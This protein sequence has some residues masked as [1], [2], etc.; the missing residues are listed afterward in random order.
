MTD[1]DNDGLKDIFVANGIYQDLTNEDDIQ[2]IS[3]EE[4]YKEVVSGKADYKKMIDLIPSN[5]IPN[6]AFS[7]NGDLTFTNRAKEWGLDEPSFSNGSAY[8]DLDNDGDLDLVVNNVNMPSFVYRNESVQLH[9]ENKFLKVTLRGEGKNKFGIGAK[10]TVHYNH[11]IA[12]QEQMPMRGFESTVDSRLNFGLGKI[13]SIDS[14]TVIWNDGKRTVLKNVKPNQQ[15][16]VKQI[17][18]VAMGNGQLATEQP[19]DGSFTIDHSPPDTYRDT[20]H[21]KHY[22][23]RPRLYP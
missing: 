14:V 15:I 7:N 17:D 2:Y 19:C 23:L 1:L 12:Y 13:S 3:N 5:P 16:T 6:Y 18:A 11:T 9:P 4:F 21:A 20:I 8:G 10:V 22:H